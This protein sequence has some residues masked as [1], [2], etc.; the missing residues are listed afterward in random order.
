MPGKLS[1]KLHSIAISQGPPRAMS[2]L[3][4]LQLN[5]LKS[6]CLEA[7]EWTKCLEA[8]GSLQAEPSTL[9]TK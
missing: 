4:L 1:I 8:S 2:V 7:Q 9:L 5:W 3:W 6:E